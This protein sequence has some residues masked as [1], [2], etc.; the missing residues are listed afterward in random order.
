[1]GAYVSFVDS[2]NSGWKDK[3]SK[4]RLIIHEAIQQVDSTHQNFLKRKRK[5][6][7]TLQ[8]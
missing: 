8:N 7:G 3:S 1:M 6:M 5:K 4:K 2:Q